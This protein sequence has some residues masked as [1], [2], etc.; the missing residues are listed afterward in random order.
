MI[1]VSANR[2]SYFY[3]HSNNSD[4]KDFF[5]HSSSKPDLILTVFVGNLSFPQYLVCSNIL[6]L[7]KSI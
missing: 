6:T 1:F 7:K 2:L 3:L 4:V 5:Y